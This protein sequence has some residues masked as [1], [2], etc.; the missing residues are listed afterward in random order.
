MKNDEFRAKIEEFAHTEDY[1]V[2]DVNVRSK[3]QEEQGEIFPPGENPTLGFRVKKLKN[4][5]RLCEMGCNEI[6]DSQVI[7]YRLGYSPKR[8]WKVRCNNCQ[9]YLHPNG[10]QLIK[11]GASV[12]NAYTSH[13]HRNPDEKPVLKRLSRPRS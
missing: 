8:H 6:V 11:G 10:E 2:A 4:Q 9:Y 5:N 3:K 7:E 1:K 12:A 13:F